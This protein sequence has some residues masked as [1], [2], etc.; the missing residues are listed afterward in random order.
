LPAINGSAVGTILGLG[1][2][3][4]RPSYEILALQ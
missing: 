1:A 2:L 4:Y 3:I